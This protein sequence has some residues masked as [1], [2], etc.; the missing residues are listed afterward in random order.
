M[1][2]IAGGVAFFGFLSIFPALIAM[3]SLYGL[4][5]TPETVARQVEDLSAQ[6]PEAA[7]QI[8]A[9]REQFRCVTEN[10]IPEPLAE[11]TTDPADIR[12]TRRPDTGERHRGRE[13]LESLGL[14]R[15]LA[16]AMGGDVSLESELGKGS[17]FTVTVDTGSLDGVRMLAQEDL[18]AKLEASSERACSESRWRR[19]GGTRR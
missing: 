1:P 19:R 13:L 14:A 10:T 5:A 15:R 2:I 11:P 12:V 8:R 3:L 6:L 7:A 17:T 18:A 4:V 9:E 16:R